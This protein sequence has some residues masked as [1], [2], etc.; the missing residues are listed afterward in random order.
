[1]VTSANLLRLYSVKIIQHSAMPLSRMIPI[2]TRIANV[3]KMAQS[4]MSTA[5]RLLLRVNFPMNKVIHKQATA[6]RREPTTKS[7]PAELIRTAVSSAPD[8]NSD[9][10]LIN[11]G[12]PNANN[13]AKELA[14]KAF[15]TPIP[16]SPETINT[17][18]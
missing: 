4:T 5:P 2:S 18:L 3:M 15:E 1:M 6:T 9:R 12:R 7:M 14:P 13:I 11:Q 8:T 17:N 10:V 16:P